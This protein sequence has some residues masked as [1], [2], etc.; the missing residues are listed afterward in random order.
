MRKSLFAA[1]LLMACTDIQAQPN[2]QQL[3]KNKEADR[4]QTD[5]IPTLILYPSGGGR[6]L[7]NAFGQIVETDEHGE[8]HKQE[9]YIVI[10]KYS[11]YA[12]K[13]GP[14]TY[15]LM[16]NPL[17]R[18]AILYSFK[19]NRLNPNCV[20]EINWEIKP[21][22]ISDLL[23]GKTP[24]N[25]YRRNA[26]GE[27]VLKKEKF[28][29]VIRKLFTDNPGYYEKFSPYCKQMNLSDEVYVSLLIEALLK[30]NDQVSLTQQ[31]G[32][33]DEIVFS[34]NGFRA[35]NGQSSFRFIEKTVII[36]DC[37][38]PLEAVIPAGSEHDKLVFYP[39]EKRYYSQNYLKQ[40]QVTPTIPQD[41]SNVQFDGEP[42]L[43]TDLYGFK[44]VFDDSR[45]YYLGE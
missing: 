19:R 30:Y 44:A 12:Q 14:Q 34:A 16:D 43:L 11:S 3:E 13:L 24:L 6:T 37:L 33:Y 41:Y 22:N 45:M 10:D 42:C 39:Q 32:A 1:L 4:W 35:K 27:K 26:K 21:N 2:I 5:P 17:L 28:P 9:C 36:A 8:M 20:K 7:T 18:P 25:F 29:E 23:N 40:V 38:Y 15:M 31:W